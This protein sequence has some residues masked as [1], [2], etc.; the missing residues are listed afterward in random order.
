MIKL[1]IG[2]HKYSPR[3]KNIYYLED[4]VTLKAFF[5]YNTIKNLI[6]NYKGENPPIFQKIYIL[7]LLL[8]NTIQL[9]NLNLII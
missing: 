1:Y 4:T 9:K 5:G 8:K 2:H 6:S 7:I 3:V